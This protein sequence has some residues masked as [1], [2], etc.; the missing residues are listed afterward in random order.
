MHIL[1]RRMFRLER[2]P[3]NLLNQRGI[4]TE[5][6]DTTTD[7][8]QHMIR[9]A[10]VNDGTKESG[11]ELRSV[12]LLDSFLSGG[13][14]D[15]Q[16]YEPAPGRGSLV[17]R[18]EGSD[19]AAPKVCLMGHTDVVPV[20]AD[21][22]D[23]DPFGGEIIDG[24]V[25]GR[26]AID[27]LNLTSSMAV[28]FKNLANT[29]YTPRGDLIYFA[30]ADEEAGGH[31]GAEWMLENE[32]DAVM[33]DYV[34]TEMGG[35]GF[36]HSK[37]R[38]V[39]VSVGEKGGGGVRLTVRGTPGHGSMPLGADNALLKAAEVLRRLGAHRPVPQLGDLWVA[40][41]DT[42]GLE[43]ELRSDLMNPERVWETAAS[44]GDLGGKM[45]HACSHMSISPNVIHGGQKLNVIPDAVH[46]DVD[47]RTLPGQDADYVR[48][49]LTE[50]IGDLADQVDIEMLNDRPASRSPQDTPMWDVVRSA[51]MAADPLATVEPGLI[52]GGTDAKYYRPHGAVVY[53]A[54]IFSPEI[55]MADF[56]SRFHG[57]NERIDL[58][59]LRLVT[60]FWDH[61]IRGFDETTMP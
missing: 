40:L 9:N 57:N 30:V 21:G 48:A 39:I 61:I 15:V 10:C 41:L 49:E 32:H 35:F 59:S 58:E 36:T 13:G 52:V 55:D 12:D 6:A 24:E 26:G 44:L 19:P 47:I 17:A 45:L 51:V 3:S 22:W 31:W 18:I 34:L 33:A 46:I 25:W 38:S 7:L 1:H 50:A 23:H 43:G 54:G 42:L 2:R 27:M 20:N 5:L 37:G 53:G 16:R 29:G 11:N 4:M 56:G 14:L 28:A 60:D 8:L